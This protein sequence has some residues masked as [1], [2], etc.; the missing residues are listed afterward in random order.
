LSLFGRPRATIVPMMIRAR[1]CCVLLFFAIGAC[2]G[3]GAPTKDALDAARREIPS[4]SGDYA[5]ALADATLYKQGAI[6]F[7]ELE[8][9]VLARRLPPHSLGD[10][11]LMMSPP[12]PP[13]DVT[14][15][16]LMM[17]SDWERTWGEIAMT[18][19]AGKITKD[20][21]DRLHAE[22]HPACKDK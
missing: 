12:P 14:F 1:W 21:Y 17:P 22:A 10:G 18:Y 7:G 20:E 5:S 11:Y 2:S 15:N 13:P 16:P 8:A 4:G 19:F 6:S 9:R 3:P